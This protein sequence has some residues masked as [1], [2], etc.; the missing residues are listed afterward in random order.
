MDNFS[1][2]CCGTCRLWERSKDKTFM[3]DCLAVA[4][5]P[6]CYDDELTLRYS[7]TESEGQT[8]TC[9]EAVSSVH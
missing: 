3:G 1:G 9:W 5:I 4:N 7:M 2:Q 8:C 6:D